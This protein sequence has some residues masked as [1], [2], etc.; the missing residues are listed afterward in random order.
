MLLVLALLWLMQ[1]ARERLRAKVQDRARGFASRA[2]SGLAEVWRNLTAPGGA[3]SAPAPDAA[4]TPVP[5]LAPPAEPLATRLQQLESE[6]GATASNSAHPR[7]LAELPQFLEAV[8]LLRSAAV[9]LDTVLQY[10]LGANWGLACA[11]L[12]ALKNRPD[13]AR[14]VN[15]VATHFDKFYPW[16]MYY[17]LDYFVTVEPRP[18]VGAPAAGAKD[19]WAD[20]IVIPVLFRDYF[21]ERERLG[22]APVFGQR[23]AGR[24]SG[25]GEGVPRARVA[26]LCECADRSSAEPAADDHRPGIPHVVRALL[27]GR[28][29]HARTGGARAVARGLDGG[30]GCLAGGAGALAAGE[31]R[32]P[33]GQDILPAAAGKTP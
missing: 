16:P 12:R 5:A 28:Q 23:P 7:E 25:A 31:R 21:S 30:A 18:A 9:P 27:E 13:G 3:A 14:V 32:Q 8:E 10:A 17:A 29:G 6:F 33:G 4:T 22:D 24:G 2:Q 20:N 11:A 19:W 15:E 26:S 1:P